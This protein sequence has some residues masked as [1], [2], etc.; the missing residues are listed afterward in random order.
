MVKNL[1]REITHVLYLSKRP[2]KMALIKH[3]SYKGNE[4]FITIV[5]IRNDFFK[6]AK[7]GDINI[8]SRWNLLFH[9]LKENVDALYTLKNEISKKN[10]NLNSKKAITRDFIWSF[11]KVK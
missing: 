4:R 11:P 9:R 8:L 6:N 10:L 2:F 7:N 5:G 1:G 3:Y